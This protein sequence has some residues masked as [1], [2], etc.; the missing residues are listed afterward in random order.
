MYVSATPRGPLS[1]LVQSIWL[2]A[3]EAPGHARDRRLPTGGVDLVVSLRDHPAGPDVVVSGPFTRAFDLDTAEQR[4]T[5]GV[6]FKVGGAGALLGLPLDELRNR[7]VPLAELWR[8]GAGELRERVLA[9]PTPQAKLATAERMLLAR[10]ARGPHPAVKPAAARIAAA[11]ERCR[12]AALSDA[13]GLSTRRF[14]QIFRADIGMTPKAYQRLQRFRRALERIEDAA[15]EDWAAFALD[16]GY[17]DQAHLINEFGAH[18]GLTP[19]EYLAA[20]SG[21]FVNHV[22]I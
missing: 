7:H 13:L 3:G 22:P 20:R 8:S 2:Y 12:I 1:E 17:Y 16:R 4:N 14:E 18:C 5:L 15:G 11:P 19:R 10:V 21:A 9:A 6:A